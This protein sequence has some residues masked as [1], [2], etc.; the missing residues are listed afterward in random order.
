MEKQI[1][2]CK[3]EIK[4]NRKRLFGGMGCRNIEELPGYVI[5]LQIE[6]GCKISTE[7]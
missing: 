4:V 2:I 7:K 5:L 6:E 3:T 1:L